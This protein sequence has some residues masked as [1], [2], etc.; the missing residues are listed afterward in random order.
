MMEMMADQFSGAF[1]GYNL[2]VTESH[3]STKVDT[4][5]TAKAVVG[6]F[7]RMG[8]IKFP[9]S[10]IQMIRDPAMQQSLM[11]VSEGAVFH[12]LQRSRDR[13]YI[14]FK[15]NLGICPKESAV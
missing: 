12:C 13:V 1:A 2:T 10:D 7:N 8:S 6:S 4:S 14:I 5:G 11:K 15:S 3:Q 9:V